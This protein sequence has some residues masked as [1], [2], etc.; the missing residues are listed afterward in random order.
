M[1]SKCV[2]GVLVIALTVAL[3][4]SVQADTLKT[5]SHEI[6]IGI[7]AAAAAVVVLVVLAI[8]YSKKRAITGCVIPGANGMSIADEK[9]RQVYTL[10]GNTTGVKPGDRMKLQGRKAKRKDAG[11]MLVWETKEV[12]K[13]FGVCHP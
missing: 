11:Q 12:A 1:I 9:E 10:S 2:S 3:A 5:D 6:E 7:G 4:T 8:H 13:D